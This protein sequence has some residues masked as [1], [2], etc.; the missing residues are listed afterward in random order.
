MDI[1]GLNTYTLD[2]GTPNSIGQILLDVKTQAN[3]N[4]I[5]GDT[6]IPFVVDW[7]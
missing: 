3:L 2:V 7:V 6:N 4:T 1:T 5:V